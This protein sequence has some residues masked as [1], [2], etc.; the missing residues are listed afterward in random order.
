ML[1]P[2]MVRQRGTPCRLE[3]RSSAH[4]ALDIF[5]GFVL[6]SQYI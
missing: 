2:R 6:S 1:I 5:C 3:E 4:D